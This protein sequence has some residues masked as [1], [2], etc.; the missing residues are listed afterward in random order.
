LQA[1]VLFVR[2]YAGITNFHGRD[3]RTPF[4]AQRGFFVFKGLRSCGKAPERVPF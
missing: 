1:E 2:R 4:P 3:S